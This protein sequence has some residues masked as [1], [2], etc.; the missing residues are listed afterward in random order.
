MGVADEH[1]RHAQ[2]LAWRQRRDITEI[3]QQRPP[4]VVEIDV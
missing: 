2:Q 4:L 3:E 1:V